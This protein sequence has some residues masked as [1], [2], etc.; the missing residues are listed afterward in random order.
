LKEEIEM[1]SI[2]FDPNDWDGIRK[3]MDEHGDN[4]FPLDGE[5][6]KGEAVQIS[7]SPDEIEVATMQKN[8][9]VRQDIYH[10]DGTVEELFDR[11]W[12]QA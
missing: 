2:N 6:E 10:R 12:K 8:G 7:I 5:N 1:A 11:K 3:L 9:W 4:I